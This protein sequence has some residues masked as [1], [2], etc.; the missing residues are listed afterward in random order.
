MHPFAK[1]VDF[2]KEAACFWLKG[3]IL[4]FFSH[5]VGKVA[6]TNQLL[7]FLW[8]WSQMAEGSHE[9]EMPALIN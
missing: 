3:S 6:Y 8:S 1:E 2:I 9:T 7:H 4:E 5:C